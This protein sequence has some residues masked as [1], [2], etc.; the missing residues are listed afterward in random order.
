MGDHAPPKQGEP[1]AREF[2]LLKRIL[3]QSENAGGASRSPEVKR[4]KEMQAEQQQAAQVQAV[5]DHTAAAAPA[6][7]HQAAPAEAREAE[8]RAAA[9]ATPA[10]EQPTDQTDQPPGAER[11]AHASKIPLGTMQNPSSAT[12]PAAAR[13][14]AEEGQSGGEHG[15]W[16]SAAAGEHSSA[17]NEA[18]RSREIKALPEQETLEWARDHPLLLKKRGGDPPEMHPNMMRKEAMKW[19]TLDHGKREKEQAGWPAP[20]PSR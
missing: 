13:A 9:P 3:T 4:L 6:S 8:A 17:W 10:A 2:E 7:P 11:A 16:S 14:A 12:Q 18:V 5:R 15:R 1:G 20:S 19:A